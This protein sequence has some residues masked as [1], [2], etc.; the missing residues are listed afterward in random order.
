[1]AIMAGIAGMSYS[2]MLQAILDCASHRAKSVCCQA[3][4]SRSGTHL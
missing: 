2:G 3:P 4:A 1:M